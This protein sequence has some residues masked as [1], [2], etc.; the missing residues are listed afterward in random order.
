M[1]IK[2]HKNLD[3]KIWDNTN[4]IRP[5]VRDM[6]LS[7]AWAY[8]D[9]V[10]NEYEINITNSDIKDILVF[11]STTQLF[12]DK[13]S[14]IDV[15]IVLDMDHIKQQHPTINID[16]MLKLYYYDWAM[17]HICKIYGR[18]KFAPTF[19]SEINSNLSLFKLTLTVCP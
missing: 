12:Y 7:I 2:L 18:N 3:K 4:N 17:V 1:K 11:G 19:Y 13:Q 15:C 9:Y 6:L 8:I 14:D 16:R 10:R 5:V